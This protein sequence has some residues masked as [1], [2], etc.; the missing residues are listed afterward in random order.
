MFVEATGLRAP[1]SDNPA[2]EAGLK[3]FRLVLM[4]SNGS[5]RELTVPDEH[6]LVQVMVETHHCEAP[7]EIRHSDG[8]ILDA[9]MSEKVHNK[10]FFRLALNEP[11]ALSQILSECLVES[12]AAMEH[13][14][15]LMEVNER[16]VRKYE[17]VKAAFVRYFHS[18][19]QTAANG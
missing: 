12:G 3:S 1:C 16:L 17:E 10:L 11:N 2:E 8:R 19:E 9:E 18:L 15:E 14:V 4:G 5:R 7:I 6:A 13:P